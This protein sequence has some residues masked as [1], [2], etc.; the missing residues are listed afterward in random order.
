MD[1]TPEVRQQ[2]IDAYRNL[3]N[4][5]LDKTDGTKE[6]ADMR[7]AVGQRIINEL[8]AE[9]CDKHEMSSDEKEALKK[10]IEEIIKEEFPTSFMDTPY[11]FDKEGIYKIDEN[12]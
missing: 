9:T 5:M 4:K 2:L 1:I 11:G 7:R 10:E 3:Y 8:I 12:V 6:S